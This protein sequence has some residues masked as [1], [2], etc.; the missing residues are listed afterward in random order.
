MNS[1]NHAERRQLTVMFCDLV[2]STHLASRL[3]PE[4]MRLVIREYQNTCATV[5][6][7]YDGFV[8][9]YMGDGIMIYFGYPQAHEEDAERAIYA[10]MDLIDSIKSLKIR[11]L[12]GHVVEI[13]IR[14]GIATGLVVVGDLIGARAAEEE[15]VVGE[16]PS[17]AARLQSLAKPDTVVVAAETRDLIKNHFELKNIGEHMLRGFEKPRILWQVINV[18]NM[19]TRF[20]AARDKELT[21]LVGRAEEFEQII[22][23]WK[24]AQQHNGRVVLVSGEAGIGKSKLVEALREYV[25]EQN[26]NQYLYQCS[27]F[28]RNS[29][30][31]PIITQL[32]F[33]AGLNHGDPVE[34]KI[35]KLENFFSAHAGCVKEATPIYATLL[36][37]PTGAS[38]PDF[39]LS[40][41]ELKEKTLNALAMQMEKL[42]EEQPFLI[43]LEDAHW[44]DPTSLE[45]INNL[46]PKIKGRPV[47]FVI[48]HRPDFEPPSTWLKQQHLEKVSLQPLNKP[49]ARLIINQITAER[50]MPE[51]LIS[52]IVDKSDGIP[53][54]IEE[55]TKAVLHKPAKNVENKNGSKPPTNL[56]DFEIPKTLRN[57]LMAR[58]DQHSSAREVA[59]VGAALGREFTYALLVEICMRNQEKLDFA[60]NSLCESGLLEKIEDGESTRYIFKHAL[61]QEVAYASMLKSVRRNLHRRIIRVLEEQFP[62]FIAVQPEIL[63]HHYTRAGVFEK[64]ADYRMRVNH[65]FINTFANHETADHVDNGLKR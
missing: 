8:A 10:A 59:Q 34:E 62:E 49:D 7:N 9:R 4:D 36:S 20:Q 2:N 46:I 5:I 64:T 39:F 25:S 56:E 30:L 44:I 14:I 23:Q 13:S 50:Q 22:H 3:D 32:E 40:P 37:I 42:S 11:L 47:L 24:L 52:H 58:L 45:L 57:S 31:Y 27:P 12:N 61:V 38:Y 15:A 54:F 43:I 17:L 53:L 63:A 65:H 18:S 35:Q 26:P 41:Q 33:S 21:G 29:V 16:T 48:S 60:L 55:L 6:E 19:E 1:I 51:E 28:H